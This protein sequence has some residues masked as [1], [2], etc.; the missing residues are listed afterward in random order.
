MQNALGGCTR[1]SPGLVAETEGLDSLSIGKDWP[2]IKPC[3]D[4]PGVPVSLLWG[5]NHLQDEDSSEG[6]H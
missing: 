5:A 3:G 2:Q 1:T 4:D 6:R